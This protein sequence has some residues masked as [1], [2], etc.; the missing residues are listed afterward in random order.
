MF[1]PFLAYLERFSKLLLVFF[2]TE[3]QNQL[4]NT[5]QVG[6]RTSY[7]NPYASSCEK[8]VSQQFWIFMKHGLHRVKNMTNLDGSS[9]PDFSG[10]H[11]VNGWPLLSFNTFLEITLTWQWK[12]HHLKMYFLLNM[13]I[14]QPVMLV[15]R[16]VIPSGKLKRFSLPTGHTTWADDFGISSCFCRCFCYCNLSLSQLVVHCW[17]GAR[18]N[19]QNHETQTN[20]YI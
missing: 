19:H 15:F 16:G 7:E 8:R 18:S 20:N 5:S 12:T 14:F 11:A 17:F 9:I 4:G 1:S 13:E 2:Q 10:S 6:T 3:R